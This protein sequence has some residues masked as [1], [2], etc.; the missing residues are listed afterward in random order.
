MPAAASLFPYPSP[1]IAFFSN[2]G[3]NGYAPATTCPG[4]LHHC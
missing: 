1:A 2:S 4:R 3:E